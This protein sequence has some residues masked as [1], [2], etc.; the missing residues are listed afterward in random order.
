MIWTRNVV[1]ASAKRCSRPAETCLLADRV[2]VVRAAAVGGQRETAQ[3]LLGEEIAPFGKVVAGVGF[4][5]VV[6][7]QVTATTSQQM[8]TQSTHLQ[9][10]TQVEPISKVQAFDTGEHNQDASERLERA[11]TAHAGAELDEIVKAWPR[12]SA[13]TRVAILATVLRD[14]RSA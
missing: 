4:E 13:E 11:P 12:L 9:G 1:S 6:P 3:S 14:L 10:I 8:S 7:Q 2:H 5:P